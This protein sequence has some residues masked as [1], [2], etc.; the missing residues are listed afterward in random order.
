MR[1]I[2]ISIG[3]FLLLLGACKPSHRDEVALP[4][5]TVQVAHPQVQDVAQYRE[6][7][8]GLQADVAAEV[9][10]HVQGYVVER[11]FMNGGQVK[12][13]QLLYRIDDTLYEEALR[14]AQHQAVAAEASAKEAQ[15]NVEYYRPLLKDGSVARQTFTESERKAEAALAN[16][17]A[18]QAA[19]EQALSNVEYCTLRSPV[20]GIAGFAVADVGSYVSPGGKPLVT[21]ARIDPIR[22][23]FSISE[24]DWLNQGGVNGALRPG[25]GLEVILP[26]GEH[27]PHPAIVQGVDN[28]VSP[29]MGTLQLDAMLPNADSLLRPGMYVTVR[30]TV[31]ELKN[32][33]LVPEES[34]VSLQGK[35]FVVAVGDADKVELIP[36]TTG[37]TRDGYIVIQGDVSPQMRIV[38]RGTQQALMALSGR[39]NL[40]IV[41]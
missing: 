18:A 32:A 1:N 30:A 16:L 19:V 10:P 29:S 26:N 15:Q 17:Q 40:K 33:I 2:F 31:G 39:A 14:Q 12:Q 13:G 11:C 3:V 24:Q 23:V 8:G 22:V 21:V 41:Q 27:Y 34:V 9:L 36:V 28:E 5:Y 20:D 7:I 37:N 4:V 35:N 25:A 6:W 38:V